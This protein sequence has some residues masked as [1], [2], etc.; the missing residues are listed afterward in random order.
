[1]TSGSPEGHPVPESRASGGTGLQKDIDLQGDG[2]VAAAKWN[3]SKATGWVLFSLWAFV[4]VVV[5]A[6]FLAGPAVL[7]AYDDAHHV[8]LT[9]EV[10]SAEASTG[11]ARSAKGIGASTPQAVIE[12]ADCGEFVLRKGVT[13]DNSGAV[14]SG[15]VRGQAYEFEAGGGSL[16]VRGLLQVFGVSPEILGHRRA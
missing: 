9:C 8:T 15:F 16:R 3:T 14:A 4:I 10:A 13:A 1:L 2:S 6:F 5:S 7:G 11:S 12:S